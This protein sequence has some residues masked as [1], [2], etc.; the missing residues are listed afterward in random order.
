MPRRRHFQPLDGSQAG[1]HWHSP[2]ATQRRRPRQP[3]RCRG[4]KPAFHGVR[5]RPPAGCVGAHCRQGS[6]QSEVQ[7]R[8]DAFVYGDAKLPLQQR[9]LPPS[10]PK[11]ACTKG[12]RQMR[13]AFASRRRSQPR[14]TRGCSGSR[15]QPSKKQHNIAREI[16][17]L[18][19]CS[20]SLSVQLLSCLAALFCAFLLRSFDPGK[21]H[22]FASMQCHA[23]GVCRQYGDKTITSR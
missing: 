9:D 4:R 7:R 8:G 19:V 16:V 21:N 23:H 18:T 6:G 11:Q 13:R 17:W 22:T 5:V 3:G 10:N 1:P 20:A 12:A 2:P 14:K 15:C